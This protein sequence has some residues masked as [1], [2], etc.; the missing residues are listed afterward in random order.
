MFSDKK[1][2]E[3]LKPNMFG[4]QTIQ[5]KWMPSQH[6]PIKTGTRPLHF[7]T[8]YITPFFP[9]VMYL[10]RNR[11]KGTLARRTTPYSV[12][13]SK[14][15]RMS[16]NVPFSAEGFLECLLYVLFELMSIPTW[17]KLMISPHQRIV[18]RLNCWFKKMRNSRHVAWFLQIPWLMFWESRNCNF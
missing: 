16:F 1:E 4:N 2:F 13:Q 8:H 10:R 7:V 17:D 14:I 15:L 12:F 6:T 3:Y 11:F 5:R 18:Q 9:F